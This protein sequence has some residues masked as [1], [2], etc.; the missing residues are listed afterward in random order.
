MAERSSCPAAPAP[1]RR[2][3][4]V[5]AL[6]REARPLGRAV[7]AARPVALDDGS[8]LAL[9]GM[10]AAAAAA[11]ARALIDEGAS[12]LASWGFAG[13]LDPAL[14]PGCVLLPDEVLSATGEAL[15][16]TAAWRAPLARALQDLPLGAGRLITS[17]AP[18]GSVEQKAACRRATAAVAVDMESFPVGSVARE[19]RLPFVC[20]RV[21]VDAAGDAVPPALLQ[22]LSTPQLQLGRLLRELLL[23]P[24]QWGALV[25][26]ASCERAA[27]RSLRA[28]AQRASLT[29]CLP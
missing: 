19:H 14:P 25:R 3:G 8:L 16:T 20:V 11:A 5:A 15:A 1:R 17:V 23:A 26:L 2:A 12:A 22:A 6:A 29:A 7:R 18:L 4:I 13:G 9:S 28:I 10:G 27:R 24:A 21:I